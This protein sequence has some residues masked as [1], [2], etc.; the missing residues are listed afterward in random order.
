MQHVATATDMTQEKVIDAKKAVPWIIFLIF[1]AVLNET[2][3]NVSTP[4]IAKQYAITPTGVSWVLTTFI[5][6]FGIGSV[7]YGR[8][9]DIFSLKKLIVAGIVIYSIGSALGFLL[10]AWY[11][12]VIFAR[13]VQGAGASAIPALIMVVVARYFSPSDRGKI[14]G[15][16]TSTVS[17]AIAVGPVVG[18]FVSSTLHWTY[19]FIIPLFTLISIPFFRQILPEEKRKEGSV[20]ILG[21]V[22]VAFSVAGITV[23]LSFPHWYYLAA[24]VVLFIWFVAHIRR[25]KEPFIEPALFRNK[26]LRGGLIVGFLIFCTVMG[27]MFVIPLMLATVNDLSTSMI[28]LIL[29]P[30]AICAVVFGTIGGNLA[31]KKG[32]NFVVYIGMGLLFVS[33]A[34]I[35]LTVGHSPWLISAALLPTYV[36]FSFIQTA[37]ANRV[38]LTLEV[39]ETGVGMGLFNLISFISGAVGTALVAKLLD[40]GMMDFYKNPVLSTIK[41]VPYSNLLLIFAAVVIISALFYKQIFGKKLH[42][43]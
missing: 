10:Q 38:S 27:I 1:F 20:D 2:V 17:F 9:S 30:G 35:A 18:G 28:G 41:A 32:N 19:L 34:A 23:Y 31:D 15:I 29:F 4:A 26:L 37:L 13:A 33:L 24:S 39:H 14:F 22:L 43:A 40:G 5:I 3:F 8:L 16:L 36:G 21:A 25:A 6:F 11:P 7:I 12:A 42:T